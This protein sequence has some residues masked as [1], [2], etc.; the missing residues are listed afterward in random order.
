MKRIPSFLRTKRARG[1]PI[2][3]EGL[4]AIGSSDAPAKV[5]EENPAEKS[6]SVAANSARFGQDVI[7]LRELIS[8]LVPVADSLWKAQSRW[9]KADPAEQCGSLKNLGRTLEAGLDALQAAGFEVK[10]HTRERYVEGARFEVLA[11][12][13]VEGL[14]LPTVIETLKPTIYFSGRLV[15]PG[16][17][18]VGKPA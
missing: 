13:P 7:D 6:I 17:V 15:R 14:V 9:Q 1:G 4:Q 3:K 5:A 10:D 8:K 11:F 18:I 16:Q 12:Q 2:A